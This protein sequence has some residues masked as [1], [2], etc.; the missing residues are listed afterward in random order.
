MWSWFTSVIALAMGVGLWWLESR[1][2]DRIEA[3]VN[4][5]ESVLSLHWLRSIFAGAL[6]RLAKPLRT[7]FPFLESDGAM[8]WAVMVVLL[9]VAISRGNP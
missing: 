3:R 7:V 9:L 1:W 5:L 6:E 2:S 8:L 4:T